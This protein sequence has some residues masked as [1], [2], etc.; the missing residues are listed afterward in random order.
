MI[1]K[2]KPKELPGLVG[3]KENQGLNHVIK[4]NLTVLHISLHL[5]LAPNSFIMAKQ[6]LFT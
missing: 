6:F 3:E 5:S 1:T 4:D 2:I